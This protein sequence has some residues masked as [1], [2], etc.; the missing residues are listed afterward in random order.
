M[1]WRAG[2]LK[3]T[4]GAGGLFAAALYWDWADPAIHGPL[5]PAFLLPTAAALGPFALLV[6]VRKGETAP[7]IER[8]VR[9]LAVLWY[10]ALVAAASGLIVA[11]GWRAGDAFAVLFLALGFWP[12]AAI[13]RERT[14]RRA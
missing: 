4:I 6:L 1:N 3:A 11:R 12:C 7:R 9:L 2:A 13:L 5:D 10:A 8:A 14:R